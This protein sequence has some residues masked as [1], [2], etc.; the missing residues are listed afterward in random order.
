M[1]AGPTL[2]SAIP[3]LPVREIA[4]A[5]A[6]Y[7]DSLGF[8]CPHSTP[9]FAIV[10]RDGVELHLWAATD[11]GWA[12]RPAGAKPVISGAES[13]LAG[14]AS[15][16][17]LV[18]GIDRLAED[19]QRSGAMHPNGTLSDKPWGTRECAALD[20]DGNLLTF[21]EHRDG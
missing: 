9:D 15:C 20:R 21:Y 6:F 13:F 12:D 3:A 2:R 17:I 11:T 4:P 16:R 19:I 7:D 10:Q 18:T 14:T 1:T 5:V 8:T